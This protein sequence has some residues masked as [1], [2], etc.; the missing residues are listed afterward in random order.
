[1]HVSPRSKRK[2]APDRGPG[3]GSAR[4]AGAPEEADTNDGSRLAAV[5][6]VVAQLPRKPHARAGSQLGRWPAWRTCESHHAT[7][8]GREAPPAR[9][10]R[11][12]R[13]A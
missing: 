3:G 12:N 11:F 10:V 13:S 6:E 4:L 2:T 7:Q 8:R 1:M 5:N 9:L